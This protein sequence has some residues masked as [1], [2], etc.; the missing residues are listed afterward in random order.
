[1][2]HQPPRQPARIISKR[3]RCAAYG[4]GRRPRFGAENQRRGFAALHPSPQHLNQ[5]VGGSD[6][7]GPWAGRAG[8]EGPPRPKKLDSPP[9]LEG[10]PAA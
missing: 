10:A 4:S 3:D 6:K 8:L 7:T 1:M 9:P 5:P 2:F